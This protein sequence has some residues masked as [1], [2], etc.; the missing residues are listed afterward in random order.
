[1]LT[2]SVRRDGY[3]AFGQMNP[4]STFP[5]LALGWVFT[6]EKFMEATQDW[7][8]FGKLRFSWGENGNRDIGRYVALSDMTS[9]SHPYIDQNGNVYITSQLY[10]NRMSNKSLKWESTAAWNLGLD[11]ALFG[12]KLSGSIEGY[13]SKTNDLLVER[14]L[15]QIIGFSSVWANLGSVQNKGLEL[16][17]NSTPYT[18]KNIEWNTSVNFSINRRKI[19][20]LYGDMV[21]VID[22]QGNVI[23]QKEADD[24]NNG[25]FIGQDPDRIW[26]YERNGV[27]QVEDAEE[28]S[29]YGCQPG[30]FRFVDQDG[31]GVLTDKDKIFQGYYTPRFRWTWRNE[32]T[33]FRDFSFSC[34]MYSYWGHYDSFNLASND[35]SFPDR[36]SEYNIPHWTAENRL[37]DYARIGSKRLATIYNERSFIRLD[38]VALSYNVPKN[39]LKRFSVENLRISATVRNVAVFSPHWNW[40]DPERGW[41]YGDN[42]ESGDSTPTPRSFNLSLNFTL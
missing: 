24:S 40:W 17:L 1:M 30:D 22:A 10:V 14:S 35:R 3:S 28:A 16:T 23:G 37:N 11:F 34:M 5:A 13:L 8:S 27:Y 26:N 29:K 42:A 21:D 19:V 9:G 36:R 33:F 41:N 32:L 18:S 4:R 20:Q 2:A 25:W 7:L 12:D 38:N 39:I 6:S 15:P 31:D